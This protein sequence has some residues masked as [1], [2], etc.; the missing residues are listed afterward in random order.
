MRTVWGKTMRDTLGE[1]VDPASTALVLIDLQNDYCA[2]AGVFAG[3]GRDRSSLLEMV[4][5][6]AALLD[7]ARSAGALVIWVQQTL[8]PHGEGDSPAWL[9]RRLKLG[10]EPMDWVV[11]GTWGHQV[12]ETL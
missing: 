5:R 2:D 8:L 11:D 4:P 10:G 3:M 9:R 6:V 7:G 12:L 1:L